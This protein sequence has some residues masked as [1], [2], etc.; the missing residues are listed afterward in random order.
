MVKR[1]AGFTLVEIVIVVAIIGMLAA[2]A[3]PA[4][5]KSRNNAR[6]TACVNNLRLIEGAKDNYAVDYGETNGMQLTWANLGVYIKDVSNNC[7]CPAAMTAQRGVTNYD[8]GRIGSDP[9]CLIT[10]GTIGSHS[11]TN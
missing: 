7:Y 6:R 2:I 1:M 3:V 5:M 9:S 11:L 8:T 10:A 4:F